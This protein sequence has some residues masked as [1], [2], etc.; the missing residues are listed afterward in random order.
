[1]ASVNSVFVRDYLKGL[2]TSQFDLTS[3]LKKVEISEETYKSPSATISGPQFMRLYRT[4]GVLADDCF[5]RQTQKPVPVRIVPDI[6]I[7]LITQCSTLKEALETW[8]SSVNLIQ[9]ATVHR[10]EIR[11]NE[12]V[13]YQHYN[14]FENYALAL[15]CALARNSMFSWLIGKEIRLN[16][17]SMAANPPENISCIPKAMP[18]NFANG[19]EWN[20]LSFD[21]KYLAYPIIRKASDYRDVFIRQKLDIFSCPDEEKYYSERVQKNLIDMQAKLAH[22]PTIEQVAGKLAISSRSLSRRLMEE[23]DGFQSIKNKVRSDLA[24]VKVAKTNAPLADIAHELGFSEPAAF[25][26]AFKGWTGTSPKTY[27]QKAQKHQ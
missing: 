15:T 24:K 10:T 21:K 17:L 16:H 6:L 27:R 13:W 19:S 7:K 9:A 3:L 2:E 23:G 8:V 20:I 25:W 5:V 4:A 26:R 14:S 1:M 11:G 22:L 12:F 18:H